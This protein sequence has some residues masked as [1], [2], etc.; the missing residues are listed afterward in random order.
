LDSGVLFVDQSHT[1]AAVPALSDAYQTTAPLAEVT[2]HAVTT[3]NM[4]VSP[5]SFL[6]AVAVLSVI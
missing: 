6:T 1:N 2:G 3:L 5:A 4:T